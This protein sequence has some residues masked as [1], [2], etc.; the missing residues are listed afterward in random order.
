MLIVEYTGT[1]IDSSSEEALYDLLDKELDIRIYA[2]YLELSTLQS[3]THSLKLMVERERDLI[4][5]I[6][7]QEQTFKKYNEINNNNEKRVMDINMKIKYGKMNKFIV[8][9]NYFVYNG[10]L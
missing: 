5:D 9:K 1:K 3:K 10:Y 4:K 2:R 8:L 7:N 6:R